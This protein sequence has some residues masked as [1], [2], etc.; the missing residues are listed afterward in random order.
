VIVCADDFGISPAVDRGILEL[1]EIKSLSAVSCMVVSPFLKESIV[2]IINYKEQIDIG[3]HL[4][5]TD[6]FPLNNDGH[7]LLNFEKKFKRFR[8]LWLDSLVLKINKNE[9]EREIE[10]QIKLFFKLTGFFPNFIDGHQHIQQI[11]L[12]GECLINVIKKMGLKK[13][14]YVRVWSYSYKNYQKFKKLNWKNRFMGIPSLLFINRLKKEGLLYNKNLFGYCSYEHDQFSEVF[15]EYALQSENVHDLFFCHPGYV[16]ESLKQVD[17]LLNHRL[18]VLSFFKSEDFFNFKA[19][20][21]LS[22]NRW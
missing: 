11:P 10:S 9:L 16:D 3:L 15:K 21:K 13:K 17:S 18:D 2:Q 8:T 20:S 6:F 5:L 12:V 7:S 22:I 4:T 19:K 1:V 14:I